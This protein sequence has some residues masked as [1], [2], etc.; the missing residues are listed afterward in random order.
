M[1]QQWKQSIRVGIMLLAA[2]GVM[3]FSGC[4][5]HDHNHD[6]EEAIIRMALV[7]TDTQSTTNTIR[8]TWSQPGGPGTAVTID[9][10]Q[11]QAGRTYSGRIELTGASGTDIT[12]VIRSLGTEHQFFF[13]PEQ[14]AVSRVIFTVT[15]RDSRSLPIGLQFNVAVQSGQPITNGLVRIELSH[16][17]D[18]T[19]KNGSNRSNETDVDI[20]MPIRIR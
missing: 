3:F 13:T 16:F 11:L 10:L 14:G 5:N 17:D 20:R 2:L 19:Q 18:P 6:D 8:A 12:E 9:T 15:D 4:S 1:T 7:L